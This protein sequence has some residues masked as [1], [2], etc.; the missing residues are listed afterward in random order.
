MIVEFIQYSG[1]DGAPLLYSLNENSKTRFMRNGN[2]RNI[3][4]KNDLSIENKNPIK[5][6]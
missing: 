4:G 2:H 5:Q 1:N 3:I 6:F